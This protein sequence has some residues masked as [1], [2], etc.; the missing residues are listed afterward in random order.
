[1]LW[2]YMTSSHPVFIVLLLSFSI[3]LAEKFHST[4]KPPSPQPNKLSSKYHKL[5]TSLPPF[6]CEQLI[7]NFLRVT[8]RA[9]HLH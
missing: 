2:H 3:G 6:I 8:L 9:G 7:T 1:M 5:E 4:S